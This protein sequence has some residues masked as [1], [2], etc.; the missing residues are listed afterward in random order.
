MRSSFGRKVLSVFL[1]F[2]MTCMLMP[3]MNL[4]KEQEVSAA[5]N[6]HG[7]VQTLDGIP[8][9]GEKGT[10]SNPLVILEIVPKRSY[11]EIG[12]TIAGCEPVDIKKLEYASGSTDILKLGDGAFGT[13]EVS[14]TPQVIKKFQKDPGDVEEQWPYIED[15]TIEI[16][17]YYLR[18]A[19]GTGEFDQYCDVT[20]P[21]EPVYKYISNP[22]AGN[23]IWVEDSTV[24][25][26]SPDHGTQDIGHRVCT[27]R[28]G[29][30][31]ESTRYTYKNKN[32]FLT[33]VLGLDDD[34]IPDYHVIVKTVIPSD[35]NNLSPEQQ[36]NWIKRA[37]LI[38]INS[39]SHLSGLSNLWNN[40]KK[41]P[42]ETDA[43]QD[44]FL[45][46]NDLNWKVVMKIMQ[47]VV[48]GS[49]VGGTTKK[50]ALL[51]DRDIY[52]LRN[53]YSQN[54]VS[55]KQITFDGERS[56]HSNASA[57]GYNHNIYKLYLMTQMMDATAFYNLYLSDIDGSGTGQP[58]VDSSGMSGIFRLG[59]GDQKT[60]WNPYTFLMC[61]EDGTIG[62]VS[63]WTSTKIKDT[64]R[65]D[66]NLSVEEKLDG[67][68]LSIGT[69]S[70]AD[71]LKNDTLL[72][73][74]DYTKCLHDY[75]DL[76]SREKT[77]GL[78]INYILDLEVASDDIVKNMNV[79]DLEP[80]NQFKLTEFRVRMW[81]PR[82]IGTIQLYKQTT[83][84]FVGKI[85]D[86]N[87]KYQLIY[88][89]M[90]TNG[91]STDYND[92]TLDGKIYLHVG[93]KVE[94]QNESEIMPE[95]FTN[96]DYPAKIWVQ[97][98]VN[99]NWQVLSQG[100]YRNI[101]NAD[102]DP[103]FYQQYPVR[104]PGNDI[105]EI[106]RKALI[107]YLA[108]NY[109]VVAA[110]SMYSDYEE[111]ASDCKIDKYSNIY[112][113]IENGRT[114]GKTNFIKESNINIDDS[115]NLYTYIRV[116]QPKLNIISQ[117]PTYAGADNN[118]IAP[119][120]SYINGTPDT[121]NNREMRFRYKID[122]SD[123]SKRYT[124][125]LYVDKN[126]DGKYVA[127]EN[128]GTK[129]VNG[130]NSEHV[131]TWDLG[132][133]YVG[134]AA[135]KLVITDINDATKRDEIIGIC[136]VR[137]SSEDRQKIKIL[138][139]RQRSEETKNE[140]KNTWDLEWDINHNTLFKQ[141]TEN[142]K[143]FEL[144]IRTIEADDFEDWYN[145]ARGGT[146]YDKDNSDTDKLNNYD[147][148]IFGFSDYYK[149]ITN[150]HKALDNVLDFISKGKSVMFTHDVT[151][152][153]NND[154]NK[155]QY[156]YGFNKNMRRA[157][158]M[159]RFGCTDLKEGEIPDPSLDT[160]LKPY[161]GEYN[162]NQGYTYY[163]IKRMRDHNNN[164]YGATLRTVFKGV[165][166]S[167]SNCPTDK[168]VKINDGQLTKYPYNIPDGSINVAKTHAQYYQLNLNDPDLVVWYTLDAAT[169]GGDEGVYG[170]SPK[171]A[172]NNYY[173]YNSGNVTYTGVG[174][175]TVGSSEYEVK[176]FVNTMIAAFKN[177]AQA[178]TLEV[179][180]ADFKGSGDE[181]Y[182]YIDS[183]TQDMPESV[184]DEF[185]DGDILP[186]YF[187]VKARG[188]SEGNNIGV[189][190]VVNETLDTFPIY[191][192]DK[193]E[194]ESDDFDLDANYMKVSHDVPYRIEYDKRRFNMKNFEKIKFY[195]KSAEGI[196]STVTVTIMRRSLFKLN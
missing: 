196:E 66:Y 173:I 162:E 5:T 164:A 195:L 147:M 88:M 68:I 29:N 108:A 55:S 110:D 167:D 74:N 128:L 157:L 76:K 86:I 34:R 10:E 16:T 185:A 139:V 132:D 30:Y 165:N 33:K 104:L 69:S 180:N 112:K 155:D 24:D 149:G 75:A 14:A 56:S 114:N 57:T 163:S 144:E 194:A 159:D 154:S 135:W 174:H 140:F 12:Y 172:A 133:D 96:S 58:L 179:T 178:P 107:E 109:P 63:Y 118:G 171:D 82:C 22:G 127:S 32:L 158:S 153:L 11:A 129:T 176:L 145:P 59:D 40:Y 105:T 175:S 177:S 25:P 73:D 84:E 83:A 91:N 90:N 152:L 134:S 50:T 183:D 45:S 20:N 61:K 190:V 151:S 101:N 81:A 136:A 21:A 156:G 95:N 148:L 15:D 92:N 137:A 130:G 191:Q 106:K 120:S 168:A 62:D 193:T 98:V 31:Y 43:G 78:A 161:G 42:G 143:D 47:Q 100:Y 126:S 8:E 124:V 70:I 146:E 121:V 28:I 64:Y 38:Y 187:N 18:V 51:M 67:K 150:S 181:Y 13:A 37:D 60:Y 192:L 9:A 184:A 26:T 87:A 44:K 4:E 6:R 93:D 116:Y 53:N 122:G 142:L 94:T 119:D 41:F 36:D 19:N 166:Y 49:T 170:A 65:L 48:V 89:G 186:I 2:S 71:Y 27:T 169:D 189:R 46:E 115:N 35:L 188:L 97:K 85:E 117:P 138:Q 77:V 7:V 123:E 125:K 113:V 80:Y 23:Y 72:A 79:L 52:N 103:K 141:Y 54:N 102:K 1:S 111:N 39:K 182:L 99:D 3:Y 131:F 160:A 17:G